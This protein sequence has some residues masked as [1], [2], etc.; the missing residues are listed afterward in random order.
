MF[1]L[2]SDRP[3][4]VYKFTQDPDELLNDLVNKQVDYVILDALGYSSTPHYL[5]PAIQ[6]YAQYFVPV[7]HYEDTHTYL[8][9]FRREE[10]MVQK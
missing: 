2:Y 8:L 3:G 1:Y 6:K 7:I 5:F 4:V 10:F 9:R